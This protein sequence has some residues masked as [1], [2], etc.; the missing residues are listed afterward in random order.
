MCSHRP[1]HD[2]R[3]VADEPGNRYCRSSINRRRP[4]KDTVREK[5][6]K[7]GAKVVRHSNYVTFQM[8]EVARKRAMPTHPRV[9]GSFQLFVPLAVAGLGC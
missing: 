9:E 3:I 5:L 1:P 2:G 6:I 8:A 4:N 7:I